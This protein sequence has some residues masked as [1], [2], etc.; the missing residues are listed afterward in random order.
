MANDLSCAKILYP[1]RKPGAC[2]RD[3]DK[4][5]FGAKTGFR[6]PCE[7]SRWKVEDLLTG[8]TAE[9]AAGPAFSKI[10]AVNFF[11]LEQGCKAKKS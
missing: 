3:E 4:I 11:Q 8:F 1:V 2:S 5:R 7:R 6:A 10:S 9:C